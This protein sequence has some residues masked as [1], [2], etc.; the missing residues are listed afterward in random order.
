MRVPPG[1]PGRRR[2]RTTWLTSFCGPRGDPESSDQLSPRFIRNVLEVAVFA[3]PEVNCGAEET[4]PGEQ[5]GFESQIFLPL[6]PPR[7]FPRDV[8]GEKTDCTVFSQNKTGR[9]ASLNSSSRPDVSWSGSPQL[10]PPLPTF[11]PK[12]DVRALLL[13]GGLGDPPRAEEE[14]ARIPGSATFPRVHRHQPHQPLGHGCCHLPTCTYPCAPV[15]PVNPLPPP[16]T[17]RQ[18]YPNS[19]RLSPSEGKMQPPTQP[20]GLH[21]VGWSADPASFQAAPPTPRPAPPLRAWITQ[22][23]PH[24]G[25]FALAV[26]LC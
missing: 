6:V 3:R 18:T 13:V 19:L 16:N 23:Q 8:R 14:P 22:A 4:A 9:P 11:G 2:Q 17:L 24:P 20:E 21:E 7:T 1:T 12:W 10:C 25:A 26:P 5:V 15:A